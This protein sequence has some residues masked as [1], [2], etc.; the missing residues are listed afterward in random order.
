MDLRKTI[1]IVEYVW[2]G[3]P[4]KYNKM[5]WT[6]RSKTRCLDGKK[7]TLDNLPDW[8]YDGSS[9]SQ[10][11]TQK[12]EVILRPKA[13]FKDPFYPL[14]L[15][16]YSRNNYEEY[17]TNYNNGHTKY[18]F[19]MVLCDIYT[20]DE[21]SREYIPHKDNTRH[22]A[23][24]IFT[25]DTVTNFEPWFGLEQEFF[26]IN[27][28]TNL[29]IGYFGE[30]KTTPQG[31]YY[32]SVGYGN[33]IYRSVVDDIFHKALFAGIKVSGINAEVAPGQWEIQV[34]PCVGLEAGDHL[35]MLRY[36]MMKVSENYSCY[37]SFHPKP[38]TEGDWNGSGC[39]INYST[40]KMRGE[41]GL[42][43]INRVIECFERPKVVELR[44]YADPKFDFEDNCPE[45]QEFIG[46][47]IDKYSIDRKD[48][49]VPSNEQLKMLAAKEVLEYKKLLAVI[50]NLSEG[51]PEFTEE[52]SLEDELLEYEEEKDHNRQ[53]L[54]SET[55]QGYYRRR[56]SQ[57]VYPLMKKFPAQKPRPLF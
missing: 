29:P 5:P 6:I 21:E 34:G 8:N 46:L 19:Y 57:P 48:R 24:N 41:N 14:K 17:D 16:K 25:N 20:L 38:L 37:V 28:N 33:A 10:A 53:G 36:I 49:R 43:E 45:L 35:W 18:E 47:M 56:G 23:S 15:N 22:L 44:K 51:L 30:G 11:T 32:C 12:S 40:N 31:Q 4:N 55:A 42:N 26:L 3:G 9:T 1:Y 54:C 13:L 7:Y 2:I 39:H 50:E 52:K 27:H